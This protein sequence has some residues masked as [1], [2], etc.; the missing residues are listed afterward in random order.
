MAWPTAVEPVNET[1]SIGPSSSGATA[2]PE[3][4]RSESAPPGTPASSRQRAR[5][6]AQPI[7]GE[8]GFHITGLPHSSAGAIFHAG[9]ASG[10]FHGVMTT[11]GPIGR[12]RVRS[13]TPSSADG[14]NAPL[15]CVASPA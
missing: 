15:A 10:K 2:A 8:A 1:A 3:P 14:I 7:A 11:V 5:A 4:S 13:A 12:R 9:I 6:W